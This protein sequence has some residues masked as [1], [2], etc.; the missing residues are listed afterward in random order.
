MIALIGL[1]KFGNQIYAVLEKIRWKLGG[2]VLG[3]GFS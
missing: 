2:A 1:E 3:L